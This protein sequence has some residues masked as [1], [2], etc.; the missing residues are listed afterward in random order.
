MNEALFQDGARFTVNLRERV[1]GSYGWE[2]KIK[3]QT[4]KELE[5]NMKDCRALVKRLTEEWQTKK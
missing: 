5:D 4:L 2:M 1:N 3:A